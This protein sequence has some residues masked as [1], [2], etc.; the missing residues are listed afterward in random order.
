MEKSAIR[1][2]ADEHRYYKGEREIPGVSYILRSTGHV[3][4]FVNAEWHRTRG[5]YVHSAC[6]MDDAGTLDEL[7]VDKTIWP[8]LVAWRKFKADTKAQIIDIEKIVH[9]EEHDYAGTIDRFLRLPDVTPR[10]MVLDLKSGSAAKSHRLQLGGYVL[11]EGD[12]WEGPHSAVLYLKETG[13]YS[14]T[15]YDPEATERNVGDWLEV[16]D[17]YRLQE[18]DLWA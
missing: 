7:S 9:S 8:Y 13:K 14:L 11:A 17:K 5:L 6:A 4:N 10:P 2:D 12:E 16:L 18:S 3:G 1:F 15:L